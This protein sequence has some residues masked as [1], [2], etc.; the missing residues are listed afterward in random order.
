MGRKYVRDKAGRFAP[1]GGGTKGKGG[2]M[3]KSAKNVKARS[4]YK[5]ASSKLRK[6]QSGLSYP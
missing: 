3:G 1:K 6:K 5:A 4:T 2:K